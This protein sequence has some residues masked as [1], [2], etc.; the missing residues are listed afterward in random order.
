V[1]KLYVFWTKG[2]QSKGRRNDGPRT[3]GMQPENGGFLI[4][5]SP[6]GRYISRF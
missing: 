2:Q 1:G 3:V 5:G 6:A 4:L